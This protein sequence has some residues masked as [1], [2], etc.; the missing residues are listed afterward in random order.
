M[1][2]NGI[3]SMDESN[4]I[5]YN[6][7]LPWKIKSHS[8]QFDKIT[9]GY[10]NNA[11]IMGRNTWNS[12]NILKNRDHY[13]LSNT[14]HLDYTYNGNKIKTFSNVS[15]LIKYLKIQKYYNI[16]VIGGSEIYKIFLNM[17]LI[18][19]LYI[20]LIHGT[21]KCDTFFQK[22]PENYLMSYNGLQK[23]KTD[24]GKHIRNI[25]FKLIKEGMSVYHKYKLYKII[26]IHY[27]D[28]PNMYFTIKDN[29]GNE[30]QTINSKLK[31]NL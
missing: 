20:T 2:I 21:Y 29:M 17:S 1:L 28:V 4:G 15:D 24:D 13:I 23:E 10:G 6:N 3:V 9:I 26:K 19:E 14:L 27:D 11:L 5:G 30:K 16:W 18:N 7:N 31:L 22:I 12:I 25:N 8:K